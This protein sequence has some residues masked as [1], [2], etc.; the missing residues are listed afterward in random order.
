MAQPLFR[1][2]SVAI[3]TTKKKMSATSLVFLLSFSADET[4]ASRCT[5]RRRTVV[6]S[7]TKIKERGRIAFDSL[8]RE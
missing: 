2:F 6:T 7:N 5:S 4:T 8:C 1:V 3:M